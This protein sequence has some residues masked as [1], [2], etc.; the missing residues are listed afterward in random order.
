[1]SGQKKPDCEGGGTKA[2]VMPVEK[3]QNLVECPVCGDKV[4]I[5]KGDGMIY[6]HK[7]KK[8]AAPAAGPTGKHP[9][10][11]IHETDEGELDIRIGVDLTHGVVLFDLGFTWVG[12][13]PDQARA[14]AMAL[15]QGAQAIEEKGHARNAPM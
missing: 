7:V 3:W 1:M 11:K 10:G 4:L 8:P 2:P 12:L 5:R 9:R 6:P 15:L 13:P 14:L